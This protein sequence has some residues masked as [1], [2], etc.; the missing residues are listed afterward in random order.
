MSDESIEAHGVEVF[1]SPDGAVN[2]GFMMNPG[3]R[4]I[5]EAGIVLVTGDYKDVDHPEVPRNTKTRFGLDI[6]A[7][8][9]L[10]VALQA[11]Q[12]FHN[13]PLPSEAPVRTVVPPG[14]KKN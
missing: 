9:K 14:T 3:L 4:L 6:P 8:M 2:F 12:E 11:M 7:A 5:R 1:K 10:L 13:L